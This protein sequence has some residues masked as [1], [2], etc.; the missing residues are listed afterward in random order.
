MFICYL[1]DTQPHHLLQKER[2]GAYILQ[3]LQIQKSEWQKGVI[4]VTIYNPEQQMVSVL[5]VATPPHIIW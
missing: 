2:R 5:A 4:L 3:K 1:P